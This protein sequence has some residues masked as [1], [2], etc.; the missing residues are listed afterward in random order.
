M[1]ARSLPRCGLAA[2]VVVLS[3]SIG[4]GSESPTAP[5]PS[6]P[7]TPG[8]SQV[9]ITGRVTATN[10]GQPLADLTVDFSGTPAGTTDRD[11][12]FR[13]TT[14][15]AGVR[16]LNLTGSRVVPRS[17]AVDAGRTR[18]VALD[19][20]AS[21]GEFDLGF[22][23]Q[24][25]RNGFEAPAA[26]QPLR[27]WT[28]NVSF[29]LRTVDETGAPV[30][31]RTLAN[32]ERTLL[33]SVPAWT[34]GNLTAT[35]IRGTESR[36]G[37]SGWI[38]VRWPAIVPV[39]SLTYCGLAQIAV[40]GGWIDLQ[41]DTQRRCGCNGVADV[42]PRTVRHEVGHAMGFRHTDGSQ[43]LMHTPAAGCDASLSPREAFHAAIAY[44]RPV[45]NTD[46]DTDPAGI[47]TLAPLRAIP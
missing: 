29:Y 14:P 19:A 24:L 33:E 39:D 42:R 6:L 10:G 45:G 11:G 40:D 37:Q 9:T 46:P 32:T 12:V 30:D 26:L 43:D 5:G 8:P 44:Q 41:R 22:Y 18:D 27:R 4:C 35:V 47:V 38:T 16:I 13:W 3:V 25:V 7:P 31:A 21:S 15:P 17:V 1:F 36:V 2:A 23:S 34:G 28:R 20:I